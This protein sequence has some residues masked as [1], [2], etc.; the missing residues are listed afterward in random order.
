MAGVVD[1]RQVRCARAAASACV[2]AASVRAAPPADAATWKIEETRR[3]A[4]RLLVALMVWVA[5]L[6][7]LDFTLNWTK[8]S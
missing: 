7:I 3:E 5:M 2:R 4:G 6:C 8:N 1:G